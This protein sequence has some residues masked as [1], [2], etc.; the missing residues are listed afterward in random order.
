MTRSTGGGCR[1]AASGSPVPEQVVEKIL[2]RPIESLRRRRVAL[3]RLRLAAEDPAEAA[4]AAEAPAAAGGAATA[5]SAGRRD[6]AAR[7]ARAGAGARSARDLPGGLQRL[8]R[9]AALLR[10]GRVA[11]LEG[12]RGRRPVRTDRRVVR[13]YVEV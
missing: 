7:A 1:G 12:G 4:R 10:A 3:A 11:V 5:A 2:G 6:L 8:G 13:R 9:R